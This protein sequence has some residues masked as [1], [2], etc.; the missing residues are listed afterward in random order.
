MWMDGIHGGAAVF[1]QG[2]NTSLADFG[3]V[4]TEETTH[5]NLIVVDFSGKVGLVAQRL[6]IVMLQPN[7]GT[8]F[9]VQSSGFELLNS[10]QRLF[11]I[12][13]HVF[14]LCSSI[15]AEHS[16]RLVYRQGNRIS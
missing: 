12:S 15:V 14:Q 1:W 11:P 7:V 9:Q 3:V 5:S 6:S 10:E 16:S 13:V 4:I 8:A 2:S